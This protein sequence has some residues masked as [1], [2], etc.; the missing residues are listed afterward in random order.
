[1]A[2]TSSI[3]PIGAPFRCKLIPVKMHGA[4]PAFSAAAADLHIIDKV[5]FHLE[6]MGDQDRRSGCCFISGPGFSSCRLFLQLSSPDVPAF[7][8]KQTSG[9][10]FP[11]SLPPGEIFSPATPLPL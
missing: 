9:F 10:A 8:S 5:V 1:M 3:A 4:R 6:S 7:F 2:A 11:F